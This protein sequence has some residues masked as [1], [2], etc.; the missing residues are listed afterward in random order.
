LSKGQAT[1][2]QVLIFMAIIAVLGSIIIVAF[3][4]LAQMNPAPLIAI[5]IAKTIDKCEGVVGLRFKATVTVKLFANGTVVVETPRG[6]GKARV[7]TKTLI[8]SSATGFI[9]Y[10]VTNSTHAYVCNLRP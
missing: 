7:L 1:V 2:I 3:R 8:P 5:K 6:I 9:I 4:P 10:V